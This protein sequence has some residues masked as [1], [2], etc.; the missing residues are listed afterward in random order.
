M[1]MGGAIHRYNNLKNEGMSIEK[2]EKDILKKA[3]KI[4]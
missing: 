3:F 1:D 4:I 2:I